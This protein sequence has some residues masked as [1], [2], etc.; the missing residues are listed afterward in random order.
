M[1]QRFSD[2]LGKPPADHCPLSG[3]ECILLV[4]LVAY[5]MVLR[6][7]D[8]GNSEFRV[9]EAESSINALTILE[10][11]VPVAYYL[12]L[13]IYENTLVQPWPENAEYEFKDSSYSDRGVAVYHGWLPLYAIAASFA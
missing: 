7:W 11:G 9:D 6:S 12:G 1:F 10:H 8:V 5:G 13:P 3:H 2:P 4:I